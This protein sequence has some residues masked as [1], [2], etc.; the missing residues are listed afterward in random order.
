[1]KFC[2]SVQKFTKLAAL[3]KAKVNARDTPGLLHT[4]HIVLCHQD[5]ESSYHA[6]SKG[7]GTGKVPLQHSA[8]CTQIFSISNFHTPQRKQL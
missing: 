6:D 4:K 8:I 5:T 7:L 1:V 2:K 3:A